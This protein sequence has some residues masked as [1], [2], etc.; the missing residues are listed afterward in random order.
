MKEETLRIYWQ[1]Y[2]DGMRCLKNWDKVD[3]KTIETMTAKHQI[4]VMGRVFSLAVAGE[5]QRIKE[6]MTPLQPLMYQDI[7]VDAWNFFKTHCDPVNDDEWW[8]KLVEDIKIP[9]QKYHETALVKHLF[10]D[11]TLEE[12]ER[13]YK[14]ERKHA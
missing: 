2:T 13:I 10:V 5:I 11:V 14:E 9:L 6:D 3:E 12:I 4:G 8:D 7:F 1:V